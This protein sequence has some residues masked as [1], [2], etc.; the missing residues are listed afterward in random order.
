MTLVNSGKPWTIEA[1]A[2]LQL[3]FERG[4]TL[5]EM[6]EKYQRTPYALLSELERRN[7]IVR[8]GGP[9]KFARYHRIGDAWM[10]ASEAYE[11]QR[12]YRT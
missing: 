2:D 1:S 4:L 5:R 3:D 10:N 9:M 8:V 7:L 6:V 12:E 11:L